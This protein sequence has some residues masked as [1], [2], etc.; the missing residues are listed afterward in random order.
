MPVSP[1]SEP[2][3]QNERTDRDPYDQ[4]N[5]PIISDVRRS[6]LDLPNQVMD[7]TARALVRPFGQEPKFVMM[8]HDNCAGGQGGVGFGVGDKLGLK[9]RN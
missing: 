5:G 7:G 1:D 9:F 8:V 3:A 2:S 6:A 4:L